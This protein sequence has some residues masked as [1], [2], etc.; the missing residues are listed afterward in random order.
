MP[1]IFLAMPNLS[2]KLF[3]WTLLADHKCFQS[4]ITLLGEFAIKQRWDVFVSLEKN[5]L[6]ENA[7]KYE[8][9]R[10]AID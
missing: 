1:L 2:L 4:T 9:R 6:I 10:L 5:Y 8:N 7:E 3:T